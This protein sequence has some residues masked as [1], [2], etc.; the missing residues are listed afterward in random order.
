MTRIFINNSI[1]QLIKIILCLF[2]CLAVLNCSAG[3]VNIPENPEE[4]SWNITAMSATYDSRRNLYIAEGDVIITGGRTRLEADYV[5]FSNKTKEAYARGNVLLISGEDSISCNTMTLNLADQTGVIDKGTIYFQEKNLYFNGENIRKTGEYTFT[6]GRGSITSC[7]GDSPDWR[8]TGKDVK[9]TI[10]GYG[11][12]KHTVLWAKKVPAAYSPYLS[13]PVKTKRQTGL[14]F[15]RFSSSERKGYEFEQ[16]LFIVISRSADATIYA[17]YMSERGIKVGSEFRYVRSDSTKGSI[18][19]DYLDDDKTDDGTED[20]KDYSFSGTPTR[21]NTDRFWL[22]MKHNQELPNGFQARLDLDIVSDEDYLHEFMDGFSGYDETKQYFAKEFGRS[23]DEYNDYTRRNE[24]YI[25]RSWSNYSFGVDA[26]WYDNI[27]ARKQDLEDTTLQT[28]PAVLFDISKNPLL[29]SRLF[30]S[31]DSEFRSF[32]RKDTTA[33]LVKG[34]RSDI[35]PKFYLPLRLGRY[36][37]FEPSVGLRQTTWHTDDFTDIYGD[38]DDFRTRQMYDVR[39]DLSTKLNRIFET[40]MSFAD[41]IQH[42]IIPRLTYE[43]IPGVEQDDIPYFDE[44]DRIEQKNLITWSIDN[45]F[46]S[47][48]STVDLKGEEQFTYK[49]FAWVRLYQTWDIKKEKN[50]QSRPFSDIFLEAKLDYSSYLSLDSELAWSP[51]DNRFNTLNGGTTLRDN[52]GDS[53]R[54]EY[55][56]TRNNLESLYSRLDISI[57]DELKAYC[58]IEEN[59]DLHR[60]VETQAGFSIEKSCWTLH[61]FFSESSGEQK[62]SFLINLHGLG[63]FGTQ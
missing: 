17:D 3:A 31:L 53:L 20:T 14:L 48:K 46:T 15:P 7:K 37:S 51:Y 59:L 10:G 13:F 58:S 42:E 24:L 45:N 62:I 16:P 54:A 60:T 5:E 57:T 32:Y 27:R 18:S 50:N 47:R 33:A 26:L 38:S 30:Y 25:T 56:Y 4:I 43:F 12:A 52:R 1:A 28:M 35:Y 23:L 29:S 40:D 44:L 2:I 55:R 49:D 9:V 11:S 61:L 22:R 21:T 41:K 8:I 34:Q 63:E 36:F 6:A 19:L 39:A